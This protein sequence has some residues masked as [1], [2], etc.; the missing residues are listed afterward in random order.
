MTRFIDFTILQV[1]WW[2]SVVVSA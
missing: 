2:R 1:T